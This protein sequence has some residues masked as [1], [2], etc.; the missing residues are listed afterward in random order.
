MLDIQFVPC[1][2]FDTVQKNVNSFLVSNV[3]LGEIYLRKDF[4]I[5]AVLLLASVARKV[6]SLLKKIRFNK[7]NGHELYVW[8]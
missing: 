2:E 1:I 3:C 4:I 6:S 7:T 8:I 5:L